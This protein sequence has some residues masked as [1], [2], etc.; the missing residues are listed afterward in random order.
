MV[1]IATASHSS[2]SGGSTRTAGAAFQWKAGSL[3][4]LQ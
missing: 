1:Q 4:E 2:V 3:S